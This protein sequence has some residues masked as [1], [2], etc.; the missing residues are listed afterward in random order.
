MGKRWQTAG[1]LIGLACFVAWG[2]ARSEHLP[3]LAWMVRYTSASGTDCCSERDCVPTS[4]ALTRAWVGIGQMVVLVNGATLL[5]PTQSV[6]RS[7]DGQTYWCCM[8]GDDAKCP[9]VPT[10]A[11]TRCVFYTGGG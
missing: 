9:A 5:L 11:T 10:P 2:I 7:E 4:V 6:H 1:F 8:L 3:H